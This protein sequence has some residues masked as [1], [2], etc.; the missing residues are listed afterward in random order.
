MANDILT[1]PEGTAFAPETILT[2]EE[3]ADILYRA[4]AI[5]GMPALPETRA[6]SPYAD[7][8]EIDPALVTAVHT[9]QA[10]NLL[11]GNTQNAFL[12]K[13]HLSRAEAATVLTRV[14]AILQGHTHSYQK[15]DQP[16][17]C[18][19]P[20]LRQY[21]CSCGS[22]YT[23]AGQAALG[24]DF[25]LTSETAE[26]KVY[27]CSRCA[28]TKEEAVKPA[29]KKLF[30]GDQLISYDAALSY[31]DQLQAMYP[32]LIASYSCGKSVNGLSIRAVT[33][34]K[35]SRYIFMNANIHP[36]ETVTTNYLIKV[37]DE[38]AYA[39]ATNGSIGNYAVK[40]LLDVFTLVMIP[41]SNPDGR[42][43]VLA[44]DW[45]RK[46]NARGVNL[47]ENFPTNWKYDSTGKT[48]TSAGSEPETQAIIGVLNSYPFELVLDCHTSGNVIYYADYDCSPA[49]IN[50]SRTIA[51]AMQAESEFGLYYYSST[52]GMANYARHP[53][54]C[55]SLTI[56]MYP[57]TDTAIDCT[58]FTQWAW[59]KLSTMPAIAMTVLN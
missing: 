12:P 31:V 1:V 47:N 8:G 27:T 57:Y 39:Y 3:V 17:T 22:Y 20:G 23:K 9:L 16:P 4:E 34:G 48:G 10:Q 2:R 49:L 41:C 40:P 5:T 35:G 32:D 6:R 36:R 21:Q 24:H 25:R 59:A 58:K 46:T 29:V 38:Y 54:G 30:N 43:L 44:G 15:T 11:I 19:D 18:V 28:L 33:L 50:K 42:A 7:E 13:G 53:Y 26:K 55:P 51:Q 56:E 37:L 14:F 45:L 52:A